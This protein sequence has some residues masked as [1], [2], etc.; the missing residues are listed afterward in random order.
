MASREAASPTPKDPL[1]APRD[2]SERVVVLSHHLDRSDIPLLCQRVC[3]LLE[4]GDGDPIVCDVEALV[5]PDALTVDALARLQLTARRLGRQIRLRHAGDALRELLA[6]T[7]LSDV[8]PL[9]GDLPVEPGRQPEQREQGG[10]VQEEGD[11]GD[12]PG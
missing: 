7:G 10:G 2:R 6:L 11:A 1:R 3:A 5:D 12:P 4:G 8:L 9:L